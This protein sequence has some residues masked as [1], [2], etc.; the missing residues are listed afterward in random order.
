MFPMM[1][2]ALVRNL[3]ALSPFA[4]FY[5]RA[6]FRVFLG[7]MYLGTTWGSIYGL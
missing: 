4:K 3:R 6:Y 2:I 7:T 1:S 5:V